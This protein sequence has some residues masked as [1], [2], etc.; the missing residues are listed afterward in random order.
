MC[1]GVRNPMG[2]FYFS[3]LV[4]AVSVGVGVWVGLLFPLLQVVQKTLPTEKVGVVCSCDGHYQVVEYSEISVKIAEM[5]DPDGTL[6]FKA[7]N[8]CNHFLTLQ[9]LKKVC[10]YVPKHSK[11]TTLCSVDLCYLNILSLKHKL[12]LIFIVLVSECDWCISAIRIY[13]T[14]YNPHPIMDY[15]NYSMPTITH[16]VWYTIA[17]EPRG[18]PCL[19]LQSQVISDVAE[20]V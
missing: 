13:S 17:N 18:F 7:G 20:T 6:T 3:C 14:Y 11:G 15:E 4:M 12:R 10:R 19:E 2:L 5:R 1:V 8:I 16:I 9:F